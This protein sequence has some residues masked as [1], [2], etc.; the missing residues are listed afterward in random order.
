VQWMAATSNKVLVIDDEPPIRK[1][2]QIGLSTQGYKVIEASNGKTALNL[3]SQNPGLIV[4]DLGLPDINGLE[5][6]RKIRG[7][8]VS[9][10]IMVLSGREEEYCKV[11]ALDLGAYDH[12]TKP[13]GMNELLARIRARRHKLQ[14]DGERPVFRCGDLSVD[15]VRCIVKVGETQIKLTPKA[16]DL[17]RIL[18]QHA[19]KALTRRLLLQELWEKNPDP[20]YLRVY[21][22]Q[23]RH[24]IEVDPSGPRYVLTENGVGYRLK[25]SELT[26]F[27]G[28]QT[29]AEPFPTMICRRQRG[30][31]C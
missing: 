24:K 18:V 4:L 17:L 2:L 16:H 5:L 15:L 14:V 10:P 9:I 7:H 27:G 22:R 20:N 25:E 26:Q 11:E 12:V 23:L 19:G 28:G 29:A 6:L 30:F 31:S 21:V 3:L 1:L 8:N 13:F